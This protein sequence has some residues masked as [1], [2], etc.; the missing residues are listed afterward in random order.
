[1]KV[2]HFFTVL[3][4][5]LFTSLHTFGQ[6]EIKRLYFPPEKEQK[7]I[8]VAKKI[9]ADVAPDYDLDGL[10]PLLFNFEIQA[11]PGYNKLGQTIKMVSVYFL[12][13]ST[14]IYQSI[15][16]KKDS[17]FEKICRPRGVIHAEV[18]PETLQPG[19]VGAYY[20]TLFLPDYKTFLANNPNFKLKKEKTP[21][22]MKNIRDIN[23]IT[24]EELEA[25]GYKV[26]IGKAED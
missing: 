14:D 1:M 13:D 7:I 24:K 26:T 21:E 15:W 25:K 17:K 19:G 22:W 4:F 6:T 8:A 20:G 12:K 3:F 2:L 16:N 5:A 18:Y 11:P 23:E 9:C 10:Y